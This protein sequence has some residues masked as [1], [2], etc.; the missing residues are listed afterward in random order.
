MSNKKVERI[1]FT[2]IV[3]TVLVLV[4]LIFIGVSF[5]GEVDTAIRA[6]EEE[7]YH[8]LLQQANRV[9]KR[10][11]EIFDRAKLNKF[12]LEEM[13]LSEIEN[14][15]L[16]DYSWDYHSEL[17]ITYLINTEEHLGSIYIDGKI[18]ELNDYQINEIKRI[19]SSF[20]FQ[21]FMLDHVTFESWVIYYTDEQIISA[22]PYTKAE[23][24]F[25]PEGL[26]A[27]EV[28]EYV[29][30]NIKMLK[31]QATPEILADG[32]ESD[33]SPDLNGEEVMFTRNWPIVIDEK[34]HGIYQSGFDLEPLENL[35]D[36]P[37]DNDKFFI[38][39]GNNQVVYDNTRS[40][41]EVEQFELLDINNLEDF[42]NSPYGDGYY[43][44]KENK[45]TY[46]LDLKNTNWK[47]VYQ[48]ELNPLS[49]LV[50]SSIIVNYFVYILL[51]LVITVFLFRYLHLS[52][53]RRL[54]AEQA[55]IK[56]I[57]YD[58]LTGALSK[59]MLDSKLL[60]FIENHEECIFSVA[61]LDIDDFKK[62]ND[63]YGHGFGDKVLKQ[64]SD[65]IKQSLRD[66][67]IICRFGGEEFLIILSNT[68]INLAKDICNRIIRNIELDTKEILGIVVTASIGVVNYAGNHNKE[69]I[70]NMADDNLYRAKNKGKNRVE[71][72]EVIS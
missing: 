12:W 47:V 45:L 1:N 13:P 19:I 10:M 7:I 11:A 32:W 41:L 72:S 62:V 34:I 29:R 56:D 43:S 46:I 6:E 3:S 70:I 67:D 38:V 61:M 71:G 57:T 68:D 28:F 33:L 26:T 21:A 65:T 55:I 16:D 50:G 24:V 64:V 17:E 51:T 69:S 31:E 63:T 5:K 60:G 4:I 53:I 14:V 23:K 9:D 58:Y 52:N 66:G 49:K 20:N 18:E 59:K 39:D 48:V 25:D 27:S 30:Q 42:K 8:G 15:N 2:Q 35:Y 54:K 22:Y 36:M 37:Y 40:I 44:S